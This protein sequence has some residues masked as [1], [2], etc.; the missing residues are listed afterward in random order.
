MFRPFYSVI[1]RPSY[2]TSTRYY[3]RVGIPARWDP[4]MYIASLTRNVRRPDDDRV[5]RSKHVASHTIN[6][7]KKIVVLGV[8]I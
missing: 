7:N 2:I 5:K 4:N 3:I 8:I 6:K 1:I